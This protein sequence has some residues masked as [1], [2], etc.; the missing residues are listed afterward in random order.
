MSNIYRVI[1]EEHLDEILLNSMF[2][3]VYVFFTSKVNDTN[4]G[5]KK[6]LFNMSQKHKN[7]MFIYVDV[8]NYKT[9][10]KAKVDNLPT[11]VCYF[12]SQEMFRITKNVPEQIVCLFEDLEVKTRK[13]TLNY[14][15]GLNN[16]E[17]QTQQPI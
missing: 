16:P 15:Y 2:K 17:Q 7:S 6:I 11:I 9:Q 4:N 12:Q 13:T 5:L 14:L 8:D 10:N 3:L 1:D